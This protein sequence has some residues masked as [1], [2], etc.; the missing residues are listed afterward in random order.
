MAVKIQLISIVIPI[1]KINSSSVPG[2]FAGVVE[3]DGETSWH[4]D[5]LYVTDAMEPGT[6]RMILDYWEKNG[7][8]AFVE[9]KGNCKWNDTCVVDFHDGPTLPCDWLE[10]DSKTHSVWME[11]TD[12]GKLVMPPNDFQKNAVLISPTMT[13][14]MVSY[15]PRVRSGIKKKPW[16]RFW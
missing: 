12:P 3:R 14:N 1:S 7:L 11:G 16:W 4:D 13:K 15:E 6:V 8:V 5:Y 2:G 9:L 10:W